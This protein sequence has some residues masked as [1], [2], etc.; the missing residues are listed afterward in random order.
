MN[1]AVSSLIIIFILLPPILFRVF[2]VKS[3]SLENPLDTSLKTELGII[4]L[5][6]LIQ[7]SLGIIFLKLLQINTF[8]PGQLYYI[9][10][11]DSKN[12]L[13]NMIDSSFLP[14]IFYTLIQI[15]L[16]IFGGYLLRLLILDKY[17]DIK[18]AFFPVT[19]R[20]DRIL[21]G[22][23]YQYD[24]L[25]A[26]VSELEAFKREQVLLI[27]Q[28]ED[29]LKQRNSD[30]KKIKKGIDNEIRFQKKSIKDIDFVVM[31]DVLVNTSEGDMI[32][33]GRVYDYSLGKDNSLNEIQLKEP[34]KRKFFD[35]LDK[36]NNDIEFTAFDS[37]LLVIKYSD[38]INLNIRYSLINEEN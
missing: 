35:I 15:A 26:N 28:E 1:I 34:F 13:P 29:N 2:L 16:S 6:S 7:H 8:N 31:V 21:S 22:R 37:C 32:Y 33:K 38:I 18:F 20:W 10:Q 9:L 14:F 36:S 19:N 5:F 11:G 24:M 12:F 4:F 23:S 25:Y 17:W 27:S 30:I 3:D